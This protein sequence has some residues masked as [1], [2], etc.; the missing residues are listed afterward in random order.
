MWRLFG[1]RSATLTAALL[2]GVLLALFAAPNLTLAQGD[3]HHLS[4]SKALPDDPLAMQIFGNGQADLVSNALSALPD[5]YRLRLLREEVPVGS[6]P[7]VSVA[8]VRGAMAW[9]RTTLSPHDTFVYY[10]HGHGTPAGL[11]LG[12]R[13]VYGWPVLASDILDLPARNVVVMVMSCHS[14]A[15]ADTLRG[16]RFLSRWANRRAEGRNF[17]VL[18][19]VNAGQLSG[20]TRIDG[21]LENPFTH[22]VRTAFE[23][24]A[25]GFVAAAGAAGEPDGRIALQELVD[26]IPAVTREKSRRDGNPDATFDPQLAAS[27]DPSYVITPLSADGP[28]S[29]PAVV[30]RLYVPVGL[31]GGARG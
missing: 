18:T 27:Y 12:P 25:D 24:G 9:Y 22:A 14:G 17:V 19:S 5:G 29:R 1:F 8:S 21:V 20:A 6:E 23:G 2:P 26:Y 11:L 16:D 7:V 4:I 28:G 3:A 15:L 13:Q 30:K 10:S 31:A